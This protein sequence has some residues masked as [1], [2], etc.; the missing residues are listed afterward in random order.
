MASARRE[1]QRSN[2]EAG[3]ATQQAER[4]RGGADARGSRAK[5]MGNLGTQL[6]GKLGG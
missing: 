4:G 5:L 3:R 2:E 6:K 1:T